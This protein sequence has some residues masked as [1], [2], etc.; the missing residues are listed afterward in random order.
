MRYGSDG[1]LR[2]DG[3]GGTYSFG[4]L[5]SVSVLWEDLCEAEVAIGEDWLRC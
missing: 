5:Y 1:A 4:R 3:R 2:G